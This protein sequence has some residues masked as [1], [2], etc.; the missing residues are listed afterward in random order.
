MD[1]ALQSLT[2]DENVNLDFTINSVDY[3]VHID[4]ESYQTNKLDMVIDMDMTMDG[5]TINLKMDAKTDFSKFNEIKE[6]VVPQEIIDSA[7]AI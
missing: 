2:A 4:K 3:L 7:T 6:I 1:E 5:E